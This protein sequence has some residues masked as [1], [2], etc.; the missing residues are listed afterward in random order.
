M[1]YA[2]HTKALK[3]LLMTKWKNHVDLFHLENTYIAARPEES[4]DY[5][6]TLYTNEGLF[7]QG[8]CIPNNE[9]DSDTLQASIEKMGKPIY[10]LS[11]LMDGQTYKE[12]EMSIHLYDE[13]TVTGTCHVYF[14]FQQKHFT[15]TD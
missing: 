10:P 9:Q 1:A 8:I 12:G 11:Q 3:T 2:V 5:V 4:K 13:Q 15:Y 14:G 7:S 6:Q